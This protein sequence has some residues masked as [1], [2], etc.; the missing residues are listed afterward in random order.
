[1][2]ERNQLLLLVALIMIGNRRKENHCLPKVLKMILA[3]VTKGK[4]CFVD[5]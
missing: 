5:F 3:I 1:M 4:I 2:G